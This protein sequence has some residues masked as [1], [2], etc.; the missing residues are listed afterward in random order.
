MSSDS[1]KFT[2][3]QRVFIIVITLASLVYGLWVISEPP[4]SLPSPTPTHAPTPDLTRSTAEAEATATQI[5]FQQTAVAPLPSQCDHPNQTYTLQR[6]EADRFGE[7][8]LF[9][10]A[11]APDGS[12]SATVVEQPDAVRELRLTNGETNY[13]FRL[14][15]EWWQPIKH[16][17]WS[18]DGRYLALTHRRY[19]TYFT[20]LYD[21]NGNYWPNI[22][23]YEYDDREEMPI[24]W[25]P[26][27]RF[28][29]FASRMNNITQLRSYEPATQQTNSVNINGHFLWPPVYASSGTHVVAYL[30]RAGQNDLVLMEPDGRNAH[31]LLSDIELTEAV[32]WLR[33]HTWLAMVLK[34]ENGRRVIIFDT[35]NNEQW[36]LQENLY[37]IDAF[38]YWPQNDALTF[39]AEPERDH[40]VEFAYFPDGTLA[41]RFDSPQRRGW[42]IREF[43]SPDGQAVVLKLGFLGDETLALAYVDG[44]SPNILYTNLRGLGDPLWSPDSQQFAFTQFNS[45][46]IPNTY[47]VLEIR[48][49]N[50]S[51]LSHFTPY[52]ATFD[53]QHYLEWVPCR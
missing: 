36:T 10:V 47:V 16:L 29:Y 27:G 31:T 20:N 13:H 33:N 24:V 4:L 17:I 45:N 51:G 52:S 5:A 41:Y 44:R 25:S 34:E 18:P 1:H 38:R 12:W 53:G 28:L 42:K 21:I 15:V 46:N 23:I 9:P 3:V 50:G 48:D 6:K 7:Y 30:Q 49:Q 32:Y 37:K 40:G 26:D 35:E 2:L 39:W 19:E 11:V 14:I 43:W 22:N 8:L